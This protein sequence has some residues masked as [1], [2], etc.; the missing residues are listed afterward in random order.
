MQRPSCLPRCGDGRS[1]LWLHHNKPLCIGGPRHISTYSDSLATH[2]R[3]FTNDFVHTG[4]ARSVIYEDRGTFCCKCLGD[5]RP[6]TLLGT[7]L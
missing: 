7:L 1:F 2:L 5:P 3:G 6:D 4:L